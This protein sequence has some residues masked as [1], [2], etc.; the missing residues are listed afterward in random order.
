MLNIFMG[1]FL[2]GGKL[3]ILVAE[4]ILFLK[5]FSLVKTYG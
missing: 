3:D 1:E 5:L 4:N 2:I